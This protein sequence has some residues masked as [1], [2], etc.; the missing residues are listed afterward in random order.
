MKFFNETPYQAR[1]FFGGVTDQTNIGW[2]VARATYSIGD[3]GLIPAQE[4][5][6]VFI[7]P[8]QT[9]YG[10][11]PP[12][13]YPLRRGCDLVVTGSAKATEPV[14]SLIATVQVG[15]FS[16][17]IRVVG[18]RRWKRSLGRLVPSKPEPL[19]DMPLDWSQTYGGT[20]EYEGLESPHPLNPQGKGFYFSAAQAE[21]KLL[22]NLEDP[23][24]PITRWDQQPMPVS[25]YP[26]D[27]APLWQLV[28]WIRQRTATPKAIE[29]DPITDE[30]MAAQ[31]Q[32]SFPAAAPPRNVMQCPE[33][34][35]QVRI[36]LGA[37]RAEFTLPETLL[38][39]EAHIGEQ[40]LGITL[41]LSGLWVLLQHKLV[42]LTYQGRYIYELRPKERR[43]VYL[44]ESSQS[45]AR[46]LSVVSA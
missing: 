22:P 42:I 6:P 14:E 12:D 44:R 16:S 39:L 18:S 20:T 8:V 26:V 38:D 1:R 35:A 45:P 15:S 3:D 40:R 9:D 27:N 37:N 36:A 19:V 46:S 41:Q 11:F 30:Q 43:R 2:V 33:P 29:N 4:P 17:A 28:A 31:A 25:W 5:W 34:G 13:N 21:E 10:T 23:D 32:E 24:E 7:E